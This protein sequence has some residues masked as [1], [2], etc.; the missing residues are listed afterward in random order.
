MQKLDYLT[1]RLAHPGQRLR[2]RANHLAHLATRMVGAW[3]RD[4]DGRA[5]L[6]QSIR[7]RMRIARPDVRAVQ[8]DLSEMSRQ[9]SDAMRRRLEF[10]KSRLANSEAH[11]K[12]LDPQQVLERGYSITEK[13]G[14]GIVRDSED[15]TVADGIRIVFA[16]GSAIAEVKRKM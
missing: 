1:R 5:W 15:L 6:L 8:R 12:N 14:G 11:L 10:A 4:I 16:R 7:Q 3:K 13:V 2:E 9:L